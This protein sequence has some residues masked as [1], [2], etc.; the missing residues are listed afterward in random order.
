MKSRFFK[1][2][3]IIISAIIIVCILLLISI[4]VYFVLNFQTETVA[5]NTI[6]S[7]LD[8]P[9]AKAE[10]NKEITMD[11]SSEKSINNDE[12]IVVYL[13]NTRKYTCTS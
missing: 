3:V 4:G 7:M 11:L 1:K 8:M 13:D 2:E 5:T 10:N 9:L 6:D 12:V